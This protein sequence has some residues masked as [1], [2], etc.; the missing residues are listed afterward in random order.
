[1]LHSSVA[2]QSSAITVLIGMDLPGADYAVL[3]VEGTNAQGFS[4]V[5][6]Q[7]N[8]VAP[9]TGGFGVLGFGEGGFGE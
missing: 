6:V 9:I 7:P 4:N 1:M 8:T 3:L 2:K 5:V